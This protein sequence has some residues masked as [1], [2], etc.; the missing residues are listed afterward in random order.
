[1]KKE[2]EELCNHEF[3]RYSDE[4]TIKKI[5]EKMDKDKLSITLLPDSIAVGKVFKTS[6][7]G[8]LE[9]DG[10][11][12]EIL[13]LPV[14]SGIKIHTHINDIEQYTCL[15]G[16]LKVNGKK[17]SINKCL[18]NESHNIDVVSENTIVKTLKISKSLIYK[19]NRTY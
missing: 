7:E 10:Y 9:T 1:M 16:S 14:G 12:K 19:N 5:K 2:I 8:N 15:T 3:E 11:E 6:Y 18:I 13:F 4:L 17:T